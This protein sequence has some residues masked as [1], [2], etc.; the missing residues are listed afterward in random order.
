MYFLISA[1]KGHSCRSIVFVVDEGLH[2]ISD[3]YVADIQIHNV[4]VFVMQFNGIGFEMVQIT[5]KVFDEVSIV[6]FELL[7]VDSVVLQNLPIR[8]RPHE[9]RCV[10]MVVCC[11]I[12]MMYSDAQ[13]L[14]LVFTRDD[15]ET[16]L[17]HLGVLIFVEF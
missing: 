4:L 1:Y 10:N 2:E 12:E 6:R 13:M 17:K 7:V 3:L 14:L 11:S 9:N 5:H 8:Q 16:A 15:I